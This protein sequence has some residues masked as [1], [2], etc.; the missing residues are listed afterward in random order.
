MASLGSSYVLGL[1]LNLTFLWGF[2]KLA[3]A[4]WPAFIGRYTNNLQSFFFVFTQSFGWGTHLLNFLIYEG[5]DK[6]DLLP[7]YKVVKVLDQTLLRKT[8]PGMTG[9][10]GCISATALS[11]ST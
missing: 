4:Y 2:L 3:D 8:Y 1:V 9:R 10:S 6:F 7:Q 5:I 11:F